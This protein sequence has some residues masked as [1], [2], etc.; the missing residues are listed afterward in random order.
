MYGLYE[1]Y[2]NQMFSLGTDK[3]CLIIGILAIMNGIFGNDYSF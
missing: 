3:C 2:K 1:E